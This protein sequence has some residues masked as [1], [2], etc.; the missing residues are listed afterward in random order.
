SSFP[1]NDGTTAAIGEPFV[2]KRFSLQRLN[3]LT[4]KGPSATS[5]GGTRN[6]VPTKAPNNATDQDWDL[7]LLTSRFGLTSPFLQDQSV[8]GTEVNILKSFDLA[9][10]L[11]N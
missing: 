3:W 8:G 6:A 1:L 10:Y 9:W 11:V 5:P 4:Y 2:K 7:W